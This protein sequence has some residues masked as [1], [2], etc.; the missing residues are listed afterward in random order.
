MTLLPPPA[1]TSISASPNPVNGT[2][3]ALKV[4]ASNPTGGKLTYQ[5]QVVAEPAGA[6][7]PTIANAAA[8]ATTATFF[9]AGGPMRFRSRSSISWAQ[10]DRHGH[11][12]R[13]R[14]LGPDFR[15]GRAC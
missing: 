2:T 11:R 4:A 8:A 5:W 14:Q 1:I 13:D 12:Q 15:R 6:K 10:G 7:A 3:T 9:Q